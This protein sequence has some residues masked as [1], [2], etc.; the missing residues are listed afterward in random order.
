MIDYTS[1]LLIENILKG[2]RDE[3]KKRWCSLWY[4]GVKHIRALVLRIFKDLKDS[5]IHKQ[6]I[7]HKK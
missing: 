5:H 6:V 7:M 3:G 2:E 4:G 1:W